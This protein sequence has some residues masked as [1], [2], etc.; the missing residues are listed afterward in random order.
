MQYTAQ[1]EIQSVN[2]YGCEN[3]LPLNCSF[4]CLYFS[5]INLLLSFTV[6][7]GNTIVEG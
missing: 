2:N 6:I 4:E 5:L 7:L 3:A 1:H